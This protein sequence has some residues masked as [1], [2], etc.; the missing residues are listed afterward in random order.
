MRDSKRKEIPCLLKRPLFLES[1]GPI[2][3]SR[4][5]E[6]I[7]M[8]RREKKLRKWVREREGK[9]D[10]AAKKKKWLLAGDE[11]RLAHCSHAQKGGEP[12]LSDQGGKGEDKLF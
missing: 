5:K 7:L 6:K 12:W 1:V 3:K 4:G 11:I 9:T 10:P 2:A 8:S